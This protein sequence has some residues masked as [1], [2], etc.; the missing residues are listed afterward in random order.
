MENQKTLEITGWTDHPANHEFK[1]SRMIPGGATVSD[2]FTIYLEPEDREK[3]SENGRQSK[4]RVN[5]WGDLARLAYKLMVTEQQ[6]VL[7]KLKDPRVSPY[8]DKHVGKQRVS[9][10]VNFRSQ[11]EVLDTEFCP[12]GNGF[13]VVLNKIR[14]KDASQ[15]I[16]Q[17]PVSSSPF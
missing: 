9:L 5:F 17:S 2:R 7:L 14:N 8:T 1:E 10:N 6:R 15:F 11:Y 4:F 12:I 13:E 16:D 3:G